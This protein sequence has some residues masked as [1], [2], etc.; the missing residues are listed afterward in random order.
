MPR[1]PT[2]AGYPAALVGGGPVSL[3]YQGCGMPGRSTPA[4]GTS[5]QSGSSGLF[6]GIKKSSSG[7]SIY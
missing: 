4:C 5:A 1:S 6:A 3:G 2:S 7:K